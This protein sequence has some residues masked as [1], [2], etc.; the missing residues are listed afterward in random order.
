MRTVISWRNWQKRPTRQAWIQWQ[1]RCRNVALLTMLAVVLSA[2]FQSANDTVPP[3]VT[4]LTG[5]APAG[6]GNS[7]DSSTPGAFAPFVTPMSTG[8]FVMPT[9]DPVLLTLSAQPPALTPIPTDTPGNSNV[10]APTQPGTAN[11]ADTTNAGNPPPLPSIPP[12]ATIQNSLP[13]TPTPLPTEGPCIHTVQPGEWMYSIARKFNINPADLI[14][15]NPQYAN[16]PDSLQPGDVL[17]LPNCTASPTQSP[18]PTP[19]SL[20]PPPTL[21]PGGNP[22]SQPTPITLSGREYTVVEGDTLGSIARKFNTTVQALKDANGMGT[23]D[24][25]RIGQVLQIP[26]SQ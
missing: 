11:P 17:H 16:N 7:G 5:I 22:G 26:V 13:A 25:L 21:S 20:L 8:G 18:T 19:P 24:F 10:F 4:N 2:C 1:R 14:A 15:A 6:N 12:T 3:T 23:G 9:D